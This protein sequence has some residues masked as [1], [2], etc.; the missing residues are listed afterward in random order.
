MIIFILDSGLRRNDRF[1]SPRPRREDREK[2]KKRTGDKMKLSKPV[3]YIGPA[4]L[5]LIITAIIIVINTE[6]HKCNHMTPL[7]AAANYG[8]LERVKALIENGA[9]IHEKCELWDRTPL[10]FATQGGHKEILEYLIS[11]G[12]DP[13]YAAS[14]DITALHLAAEAGNSEIVETLL[15]HKVAVNIL[16]HCRLTPLDYA[17][18]GKKSTP[19]TVSGKKP[20]PQESR[21]KRFDK[22]IS[23]LRAHDAKTAEELKRST[24]YRVPGTE[25]KQ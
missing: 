19:C 3:K 12:A 21:D 5:V 22:T 13:N 18:R 11:A 6:E 16:E 15:K 9:D 1:Y 23:L 24:K 7:M 8:N 4:I 14:G 10:I 2:V 17:L 20:E 25:K